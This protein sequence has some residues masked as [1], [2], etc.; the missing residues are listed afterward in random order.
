MLTNELTIAPPSMTTNRPAG[1][2]D[3][4]AAAF[5]RLRVLRVRGEAAFPFTIWCHGGRYQLDKPV[6]LQAEDTFPVTVKACPGEKP[7]FDGGL[8]VTGWQEVFL[9]GHTMLR[10]EVPQEAIQDGRVDQLFVNGKRK[11]R[12]SFPKSLTGLPIQSPLGPPPAN[13]FVGANGFVVHPGDFDPS[14]YDHQGIECLLFQRWIDNHLPVER[15]DPATGIVTFTRYSRFDINAQS[16]YVWQNVREALT[17]PGEF[18]F[19]RQEK[20]LYY[21]P[22]EGESASTLEAYVPVLPVLLMLH[23]DP[24]NGQ[25]VQW[26]SFEGLTFRHSGG[27]RPV[28]GPN[29]DLGDCDVPPMRNPFV[30]PSWKPDTRPLGGFPQAS[31]NLPA[32]IMLTGAAHCAFRQCTIEHCGATA[33]IMAEGCRHIELSRNEL[34]DLGGGGVVISGNADTDAA[35]KLRTSHIILRDNHIHDGGNVFPSAVGIAIGHAFGNLIEHNH[36]HDFYYSAISCGWVWGYSDSVCRE[37]RIGFNLI[38][39]I[40]K[41]VLCDMGGIYLLGIQPGT[42]VYNNYIARVQCRH[43]GGWG[44]Y[45]DE[46]SAHIVI[47]QNICTDCSREGFHQHYGRENIARHNVSAFPGDCGIAISRSNQSR[48]DGFAF[49]GLC[50]SFNYNFVANVIVVDNKP[51]FKSSEWLTLTGAQLLSESNVFFDVSASAN[52]KRQAPFFQAIVSKDG[53]ATWQDFTFAD[54]QALG[55]DAAS[56]LADPGFMNLKKRD[57]R[58]KKN[59][60]LRQRGF[61]DL[62]ATITGAGLRPLPN[63]P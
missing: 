9:N 5:A 34:S 13:F 16:R 4:L 21:Y 50:H 56:V 18:Y 42:R 20:A 41:Q 40:G 44:I 61:P 23:G 31:L 48:Q 46:G 38:H 30:K 51:F 45:T 7:V 49:P 39:D 3:S 22:E 8:P 12:A 2:L 59:S 54:W 26:L 6:L 29:Y 35:P 53:V 27:G 58:L 28:T 33:L 55:H 63:D 57:F 10:A 47:E 1:A 25:S 32:A 19:D 36:I 37:N 62:A 60:L 15:F 24:E 11:Q 52:S 14:W 43:Y 17:E